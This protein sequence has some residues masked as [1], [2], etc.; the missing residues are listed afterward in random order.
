VDTKGTVRV[1]DRGSGA[2]SLWEDHLDSVAGSSWWWWNMAGIWPT[3]PTALAGSDGTVHVF[4]V[5][6]DGRLYERHLPPG[7][8][9]RWTTWQKL[10]GRWQWAPAVVAGPSGTA[11]VFAVGTDGHLYQKR[12]RAS[13]TWGNWLYVGASGLTGTPAATVDA[14]G[15]VRVYV[16]NVW[17]ALRAATLTPGH[18]WSWANLHGT[19]RWNPAALMLADGSSRVYMVGTD[20]HLYEKHL[21]TDGHWGHWLNIGTSMLHGTPAAVV[22]KTGVIR[23]YVRRTTGRLMEKYLQPG[24]PWAQDNR[25]APGTTTSPRWWTTATSCASTP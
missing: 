6:T 14:N 4:S 15:V 18:P 1:Y 19:W 5:G 13:G 2:G 3:S 23:V 11:R 16:R 22:D 17:G 7:H 10:G 12:L 25:A 9:H 24:S 21:Y 20:G 8:G